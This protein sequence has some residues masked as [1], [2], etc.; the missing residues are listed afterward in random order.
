L[1]QQECCSEEKENSIN[2]LN[3]KNKDDIPYS[4]GVKSVASEILS[5]RGSL[6]STENSVSFSRRPLTP[7]NNMY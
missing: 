6:L 1:K 2:T 3:L 7:G 4:A 5:S